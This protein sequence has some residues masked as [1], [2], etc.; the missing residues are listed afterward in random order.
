MKKNLIPFI[1]VIIIIGAC[2]SNEKRNEKA[3]D[4][5][6][7]E[8]AEVKN[9]NTSNDN[10]EISIVTP[11]GFTR[12]DTTTMGQKAIFL[13]SDREGSTDMFQENLNVIIERVGDISFDSYMELTESNM[14]KFLQKYKKR[15]IKDITVDGTPAKSFDYSHSMGMYDIDANAVI[16]MKNEKAYIITSTALAGGMSKWKPKFDE[17]IQSFHVE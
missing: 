8:K 5:A 2:K 7:T 9:I 4:T 15:G 16:L 11:A 12:I 3:P 10:S 1:A 13:M 6:K 14:D 17:A